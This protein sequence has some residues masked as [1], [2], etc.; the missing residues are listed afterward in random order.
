[1]KNKVIRFLIPKHD[2][3]DL[4]IIKK[5]NEI[6]KLILALTPTP[7]ISS[8]ALAVTTNQVHM[9]KQLMSKIPHQMMTEIVDPLT[10]F[11]E[12]TAEYAKSGSNMKKAQKNQARK[13]LDFFKEIITV[14]CTVICD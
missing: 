3:L 6:F 1:M 8:L 13:N 12:K 5:N 14:Q 11:C 7:N 2:C 10:I 4:S 9:V